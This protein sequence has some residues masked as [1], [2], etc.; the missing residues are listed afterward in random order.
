MKSHTTIYLRVML[1]AAL[2]HFATGIRASED[3]NDQL[4]QLTATGITYVQAEQYS[5]AL[6][7]FIEALKLAE[8]KKN[9]RGVYISCTNI[10]T[11]FSYTKD[12][13]NALY[14]YRKSYD[15]ALKAKDSN[16]QAKTLINIV[17]TYF[18]MDDA[19]NARRY[20]ELF[21]KTSM[22]DLK[23]K[24]Y[25]TL[26]NNA[27][28]A[29]LEKK[30]DMARY[31]YEQA[32]KHLPEEIPSKGVNHLI[33]L[34]HISMDEGHEDEAISFFLKAL[35][36]AA[37][38]GQHRSVI[39]A[40][41]QLTIAYEKIGDKERAEYYKNKALATSDTLFNQQQLN[42]SKSRLTDFER[43]KSQRYIDSLNTSLN[44][45]L[46]VMA[47]VALLLLLS[48]AFILVIRRKNKTLTD[49]YELLIE[50]NKDLS[51][52][53][54]QS[55]NLRE[56]YLAVLDKLEKVSSLPSR[57][58]EEA[59]CEDGEGK[60]S[61][62]L[63][64]EQM[65][66]LAR[67]ITSVMEDVSVISNP[68]FN[69]NMLVQLTGSNTTYVSNVINVVFGKNFKA[70]LNEYRINEACKRLVDTEHYGHMTIEAIYR[71]LGYVSPTVFINAFKKVNGMTPS[72]YQ[73]LAREK[74]SYD[75]PIK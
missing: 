67:K 72:Q 31:Y 66:R 52:Q 18:E 22:D 69:Q 63:N 60:G 11:V 21:I 56:Q 55:K 32:M 53:A 5:E 13:S 25:Y 4:R 20:N 35:A 3:V 34:G 49:S 2:I 6:D 17:G 19:A 8:R 39:E 30:Y 62:Y 75:E 7:Y 48:M 15:A 33:D 64:E 57:E 27:V 74:N 10:G 61:S 46:V 54:E 26:Y 71:E 28:V 73:K 47:F 70:M 23:L 29:R 68:D 41:E 45:S 58:E 38:L 51:K 44:I 12:Y 50:K 1:I 16:S 14:Y 37:G 40:C 65:A 9:D 43:D 59:S 42:F 24:H 36:E